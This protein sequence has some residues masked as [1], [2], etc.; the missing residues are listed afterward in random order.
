MAEIFVEFVGFFADFD[1]AF[2]WFVDFAEGVDEGVGEVVED[3]IALIDR[4]AATE[5]GMAHEAVEIGAFEESDDNHLAAEGWME[6]Y[7]FEEAVKGMGAALSE[8]GAETVA[9]DVFHLV[10]VWQGRDGVDGELCHEGFVKPDEVGKAAAD[11]VVWFCKGGKVGLGGL[12]SAAD[13]NLWGGQAYVGCNEV[14]DIGILS[15]VMFL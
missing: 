3:A 12:M 9:T 10:L 6:A 4:G 1:E 2:I 14:R 13:G 11:F 8:I 7:A 5:G 15:T